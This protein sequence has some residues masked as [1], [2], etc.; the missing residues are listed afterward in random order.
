MKGYLKNL[1]YLVTS[2]CLYVLP[3]VTLL[4]GVTRYKIICNIIRIAGNIMMQ[5][6]V[7][8]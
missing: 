8:K 4:C 6:E 2:L 7:T 3:L 1:V 5:S